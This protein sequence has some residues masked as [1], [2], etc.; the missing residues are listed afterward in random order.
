VVGTA[1]QGVEENDEQREQYDGGPP[2]RKGCW[3]KSSVSA[4]EPRTIHSTV[5]TSSAETSNVSA[6]EPARRSRRTRRR[7]SAI[8]FLPEA[9]R[10][11]EARSATILANSMSSNR[12]KKRH[13]TVIVPS[14]KLVPV[15]EIRTLPA[16]CSKG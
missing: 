12:N 9:S 6:A 15:A 14:Q 3:K 16:L 10:A 5:N 8:L 2:G 13:A 7:V 11:A 4:S 1:E